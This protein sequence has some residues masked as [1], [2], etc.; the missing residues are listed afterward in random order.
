MVSATL[1]LN[2][3]D[4]GMDWKAHVIIGVLLLVAHPDF[5]GR[6]AA[7]QLLRYGLDIA[8]KEGKQT[9]IEASDAGYPLYAKLGWE[10]VDLIDIEGSYN[11]VMIRQP[12]KP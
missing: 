3:H 2:R 6:G 5:Q 12:V 7:T 9:Y 8:D 4:I 11:R 1:D 10:V